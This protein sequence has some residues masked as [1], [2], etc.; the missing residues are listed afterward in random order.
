MLPAF[1]LRKINL[2]TKSQYFLPKKQI[3]RSLL[4]LGCFILLQIAVID[5]VVFGI[6][7]KQD[8]QPIEL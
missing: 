1:F 7:Q 2:S 4:E 5:L 3:L 6:A 8:T